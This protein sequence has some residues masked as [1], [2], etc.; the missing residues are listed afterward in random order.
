MRPFIIDNSLR[1]R[2]YELVQNA[3]ANIYTIDD[4][5]D[6]YKKRKPPPGDLKNFTATLPFGYKIVYSIEV[7]L[8]KRVRHLSVSVN[9]QHKLPNVEVVKEIMR[10]IGFTNDLKKCFV[11]LEDIGPFHQAIN[12]FEVIR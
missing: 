3:E 1:Q 10:T 11:K 6:I 9:Q 12:V 5:L 2:L 7:Q 8:T 4:L